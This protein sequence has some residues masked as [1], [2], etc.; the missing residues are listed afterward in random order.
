MRKPYY[1]QPEKREA[2]MATRTIH[3][4]YSGGKETAEHY[5][6]RSMLARCNNPNDSSYPYYGG[7]GINVCDKWRDYAAFLADMGKRP[8]TTHSLDRIDV[9]GD[10]SPGNCRWATRSEQQKNKT[11]TR[12]YTN[13]VFTGTLVE[14]ATLLGISKESAHWRWKNWKTFT[15]G[16]VWHEL[17]KAQ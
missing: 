5:I 1:M 12:R 10:Y 15:K 14:C 13:G 9:D 16:E 11:G 3:G 7:R 6:W 4:G 2:W 17:R 8:T